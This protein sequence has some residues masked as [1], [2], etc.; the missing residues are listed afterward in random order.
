MMLQ[1]RK[2]GTASILSSAFLHKHDTIDIYSNSWA[3]ET[4][5]KYFASFSNLTNDAIE[6]GIKQVMS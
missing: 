6:T 5:G 2:P 3:F 4:A 1:D